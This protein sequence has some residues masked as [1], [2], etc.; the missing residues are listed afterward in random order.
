MDLNHIELPASVIAGLYT[1]HLVETNDM[2]APNRAQ[3][4]TVTNENEENNK[5]PWKYL[6]KNQKQILVIIDNPGITY[7]PDHE[8]AFLTGILNACKLSIDDTAIF[9]IANQSSSY[10]ELLVFFKSRIVLLFDVEPSNFGLPMNFPPYQIQ[11]FANNSFLFSPSLRELENDRVEK[12]KL[13]VC[14][15]RLFN[16]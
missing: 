9:N 13:W 6:G 10:K 15:K 7:L 4:M 14:L 3:A 1:D 12:S 2:P 5:Y 11:A 16:L 8:L